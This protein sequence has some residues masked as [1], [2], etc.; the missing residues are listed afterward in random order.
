MF[1]TERFD[2]LRKFLG[3]TTS[4]LEK[5]LNLSN[6][7]IGNIEKEGSKHPGKL[8]LA[9][10]AKGISID[11]F[12]TGQGSIMRS[13][14]PEEVNIAGNVGVVKNLGEIQNL[15]MM[16]PQISLDTREEPSIETEISGLSLFEIP[17]LS[18]E[19]VLRFDPA[20]EIPTPKAHSGEYPVRTLVP[21]PMRF[22]EYSTDLRAMVV[23]NG[24]M[25]PLLTPGDVAVFQ[26]TGWLGDGVYVYRVNGDLHIG[27]ARLVKGQ[28]L[29]ANEAKPEAEVAYDTET[30]VP[31][32]RVRA[33]VREIG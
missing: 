13:D 16:P 22:Q 19:Q 25:A 3:Q 17:L 4:G 27:H 30:F 28:Y 14:T 8:L 21:I 33:V 9:L 15:T 1:F 5:I 12:L 2:E 6:G 29:V 26:A 11:W 31:I 24:L 23:F 18:K 20:K 10:H 7:Y 32:G